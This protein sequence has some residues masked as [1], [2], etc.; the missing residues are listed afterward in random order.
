MLKNLRI[1]LRLGIGF[2][3]VLAVMAILVAVA[4]AGLSQINGVVTSLGSD[5]LPKVVATNTV[6]DSVNVVARAMRNMAL[7]DDPA[8]RQAEAER[9]EE[10]RAAVTK[11]LDELTKTITSEKGKELLAAV[12]ANDSAEAARLLS[13]HIHVP[14]RILEEAPG[15]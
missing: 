5:R 2:G 11:T 14:Q 9:V 8:K 15:V 10:A 1:G 6:I 3:L 13:E 7:L 4:F 12:R